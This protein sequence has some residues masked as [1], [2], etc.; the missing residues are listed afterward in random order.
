MIH[1]FRRLLGGGDPL[2]KVIE[3]I[4]QLLP[5][6][7]NPGTHGKIDKCPEWAPDLFGVVATLAEL[8][9]AYA[10]PRFTAGWDITAYHYKSPYLDSVEKAAKTWNLTAKPSDDA[11]RLWEELLTKGDVELGD[12]EPPAPDWRL[13]TMHLLA[14]ADEA[15]AGVGFSPKPDR[16]FATCVYKQ[17]LVLLEHEVAKKPGKAKLELPHLPVSICKMISDVQLCVQ[18]KTNTPQVGCTLRSLTHHLALLPAKGTVA[19]SWLFAY[20][21]EEQ[22]SDLRPLNVLLVPYPYAV[23]GQD[24]VP[25]QD[26]NKPT[27]CYFAVEPNW[28]GNG[29]SRVDPEQIASFIGTLITAAEREVG[30][31]HAVVFP[32]GALIDSLARKVARLLAPIAP[33]LELFIAGTVSDLSVAAEVGAVSDESPVATAPAA[34]RYLPRNKAYTCRLYKGELLK[35]WDQSKHHRWCLESSQIPRYHLGHTLDP[36]HKWWEKIDVEDRTCV[37][38]LVRP[39]ASLAVL[40]CEDLARFDPVLPLINSIG[41][42][43]VIALLMDGPQLERRWPGRYA[44]VLA[45]DPGS[46]VLTLTCIG[47]IRRSAPQGQ[48]PQKKIALW[49]EPGGSAQELQLGNDDLALALTLN[50]TA[51]E[52][53]TM[54]RRS[55]H[56]GTRQFRLTAAYNVRVPKEE[57]PGWLAL[58]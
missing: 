43:L 23:R 36:G 4:Q 52:Q 17:H 58:D 55:D 13:T 44:T 39:G 1:V 32:E 20:P 46:S 41:P 49:K 3:I 10:E 2:P 26:L 8:S 21:D 28:L 38:T 45:D 54:D 50:P 57:L 16:Y 15:S 37:F 56:S 14:I 9:G 6:G 30:T 19:S 5:R 35:E 42:S 22:V 47:M 25:V 7:S 33:K 11:Q 27:S 51:V 24:F 48:V 18:P 29:H 53:F 34:V 12:D 31:I 40:V